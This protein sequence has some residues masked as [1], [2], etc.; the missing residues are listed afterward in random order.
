MAAD[1]D[2]KLTWMGCEASVGRFVFFCSTL[3][4]HNS[5]VQVFFSS[6]ISVCYRCS[7]LNKTIY[8]SALIP[9]FT[10][11]SLKIQSVC[12]ANLFKALSSC[13]V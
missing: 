1:T 12:L 7:K 6:G 4:E 3:R 13:L 2:G 5:Q 11:D 9:V 8:P 10:F